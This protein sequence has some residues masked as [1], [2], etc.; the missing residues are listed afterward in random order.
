MRRNA[1]GARET[2]QG[3]AVSGQSE[4]VALTP[5][6]GG[7]LIGEAVLRIRRAGPCHRGKTGTIS[8]RRDVGLEACGCA[9]LI[10]GS[11]LRAAALFL[12]G[13][14]VPC[15]EGKWLAALTVRVLS[16][17]AVGDL[18]GALHDGDAVGN[19]RVAQDVSRPR[20][21]EGFRE[22]GD[23]AVLGAGGNDSVAAAERRDDGRDGRDGRA[24]KC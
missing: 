12:N 24:G 23:F 3:S 16:R 2:G 7:G 10:R 20:D 8:G 17:L 18:V 21:A 11:P 22:G 15:R 6:V 14:V 1:V 19:E 5:Q 13:F 9:G 4:N